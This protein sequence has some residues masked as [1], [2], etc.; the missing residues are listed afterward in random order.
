MITIA[1]LYKQKM[2][3]FSLNNLC[4]QNGCFDFIHAFELILGKYTVVLLMELY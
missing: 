2:K 1:F 4:P 3:Q